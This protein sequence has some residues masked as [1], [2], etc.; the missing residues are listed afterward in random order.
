M[1]E[2][3]W[4]GAGEDLPRTHRGVPR[5]PRDGGCAHGEERRAVAPSF[6]PVA[7]ISPETHEMAMGRA[8]RG[9]LTGR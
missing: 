8:V 6:S 2:R 4:Q 3:R 1:L 5:G 7:Q 9:P